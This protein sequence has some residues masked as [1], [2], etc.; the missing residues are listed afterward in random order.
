MM[1]VIWLS[2]RKNGNKCLNF[3]SVHLLQKRALLHWARCTE[4]FYAF[5]RGCYNMQGFNGCHYTITLNLRRML[6]LTDTNFVKILKGR[7]SR[8]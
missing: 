4:H 3:T 5:R 8:Q 2:D 6:Y 1:K 7:T